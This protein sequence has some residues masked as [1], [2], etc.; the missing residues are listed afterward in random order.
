MALKGDLITAKERAGMQY[1]SAT[2]MLAIYG[3]RAEEWVSCTVLCSYRLKGAQES[4]ESL[5]KYFF[6]LVRTLLL[7][8]WPLCPQT[9]SEEIDLDY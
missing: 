7:K 1:E 2:D 8:V 6:T 4:N 3:T 5:L 9:H